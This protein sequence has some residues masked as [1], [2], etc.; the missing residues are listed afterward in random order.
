[1]FILEA[2]DQKLAKQA[3][4]LFDGSRLHPNHFTTFGLAC[5]LLAAALYATGVAFLSHVAAAVFV[6]AVWMDHVDGEYARA[7]AKTSKFGH[8]YDHVS[9]F[10]GYVAIF[11]GVGYGLRDT[12]GSWALPMGI[13]AGLAIAITFTVRVIVEERQ[14]KAMVQQENFFGFEIEDAL[15]VVAP[16]TWLGGLNWLLVAASIAA[17]LFMVFVLVQTYRGRNATSGWS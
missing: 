3:V 14:G 6:I 12:F 4:K 16:I 13:V 1:V 5:G 15:Y 8:Y 7:S 11:I 9:A 17:P 2:W 10:T